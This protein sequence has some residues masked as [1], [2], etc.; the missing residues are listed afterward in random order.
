M[1]QVLYVLT[2]ISLLLAI[3][4]TVLSAYI[5]LGDSGIDCEPWPSC[6]Q[7]S[8]MIDDEPG[9]SIHQQDPNKGLRLLHRLMAS[10][11]GLVVIVLFTI[12]LWYRRTE[13]VAG[14]LLLFLL[15]V[16]LAK[17]KPRWLRV[18]GHF[19][20]RGGIAIEVTAEE[21]RRSTSVSDNS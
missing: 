1:R 11:F 5:R 18:T 12:S 2:L 10:T 14:P 16:L 7:S 21:P 8:F 15:T 17:L 9:I 4:M 19:N 3:A 6:F 20:I 13:R